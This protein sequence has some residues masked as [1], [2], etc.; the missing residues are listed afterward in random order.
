[1]LVLLAIAALAVLY[2]VV[3][4]SQG[5]G[6]QL[7][8]FAPDVPPLD[9][10]DPG[11]LTAVDVMA[12]QLPVSLVGYNT[13]SVD[14]T[15]HRAATA[16]GERDTHIAVLEQRLAELLADRVQARK[17]K[18]TFSRPAWAPLASAP[19]AAELLAS[20]P[21]PAAEPLAVSPPAAG[22]LASGP[23]AAPEVSE[24]SG[25]VPEKA[26][27]DPVDDVKAQ[28]GDAKAGANGSDVP[29]GER[30]ASKEA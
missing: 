29:A 11:Q 18:E 1:M 13:R 4:V 8:E 10:P 15:L 19:P 3:M 2:C 14:E 12:L 20:A 5:R 27:D 7:A 16:L 23:A 17:D 26:S 24:P 21:P 28:P 25:S 9:L 6:G 22:P 30:P